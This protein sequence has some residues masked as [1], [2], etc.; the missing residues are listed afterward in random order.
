MNKYFEDT[1]LFN[2][3]TELTDFLPQEGFQIIKSK[4][5]IFY[6]QGG[7]QPS[8]TG[9]IRGNGFQF[10]VEKTIKRE[11]EILHQGLLKGTP[12]TGS[13]IISQE[14]DQQKRILHAQIHSAG[15]MVDVAM[16]RA[17]YDLYPTKGYHFVDSPYVEYAGSIE[18]EAREEIIPELNDELKRLIKESHEIKAVWRSNRSEVEDLCPIVPD[19][20]NFQDP[21]RIVTVADNYGCPCAGTH[22]KNTIEIPGIEVHKIKVKGGNTRVSYRLVV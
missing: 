1:Y 14:I 16:V 11:G 9:H 18:N 13:M 19:Y 12:P 20:L 22:V 17:G 4:D 6:P 7:G 15:H 3:E 5:T 21:V 8:D 2:Y 10:L